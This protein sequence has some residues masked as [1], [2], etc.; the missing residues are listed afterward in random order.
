MIPSLVMQRL[1]KHKCLENEFIY[2]LN[3][4]ECK[5]QYEVFEKVFMTIAKANN[6]C[7]KDIYLAN[8]RSTEKYILLCVSTILIDKLL[9]LEFHLTVTS[10]ELLL[11]VRLNEIVRDY[12]KFI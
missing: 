5:Y 12:Y 4:D 6:M 2:S 7:W 8:H 10:R 9:R 3:I 1:R 11:G